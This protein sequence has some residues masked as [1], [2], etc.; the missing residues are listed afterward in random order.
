MHLV[1]ALIVIILSFSKA[2]SDPLELV[3]Y[4]EAP[5]QMSLQ[6][7]FIYTG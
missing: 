3:G 5:P 4:A 6:V 7:R 1:I 2:Q